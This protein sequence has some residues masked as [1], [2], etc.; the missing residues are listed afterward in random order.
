MKKMSEN[1]GKNPQSLM[2]VIHAGR[3]TTLAAAIREEVKR[4]WDRLGDWVGEGHDLE[5]NALDLQYDFKSQANVWNAKK[6]AQGLLGRAPQLKYEFQESPEYLQGQGLTYKKGANPVFPYS[7]LKEGDILY[8]K[9]HP[10][11]LYG[12]RK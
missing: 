6:I 10:P 7:N 9:V 2:I 11:K 3:A 1:A 12:R 5:Q 4:R 8:G